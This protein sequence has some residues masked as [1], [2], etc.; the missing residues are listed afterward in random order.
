MPAKTTGRWHSLG[1]SPLSLPH[2]LHAAN[3]TKYPL[4]ANAAS[5]AGW[6]RVAVD[7]GGAI[8]SPQCG[9]DGGAQPQD[10]SPGPRGG[11]LI[12]PPPPWRA[13]NG[14]SGGSD[15]RCSAV[16]PRAAGWAALPRGPPARRAP[17]SHNSHASQAGRDR[18]CIR[19]TCTTAAVSR[20]PA[21][22]SWSALGL[23]LTLAGWLGLRRAGQPARLLASRPATS[24]DR[25]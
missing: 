7:A 9:A 1:R 5:A 20:P 19:L 22:R 2:L 4:A 14:R 21:S 18:D 16:R 12:A 25:Y 24:A 23:Q 13:H 3:F 17:R 15:R 8:H 10:H 11:H 6:Q